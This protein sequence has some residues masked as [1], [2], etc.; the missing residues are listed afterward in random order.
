MN[1]QDTEL[2]ATEKR[3][4]GSCFGHDVSSSNKGHTPWIKIILPYC[5]VGNRTEKNT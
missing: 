4:R 3:S 5:A 1:M 2:L